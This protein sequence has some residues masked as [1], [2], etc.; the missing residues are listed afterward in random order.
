MPATLLDARGNEAH[1]TPY[2]GFPLPPPVPGRYVVE[3]NGN[4]QYRLPD[5]VTGETRSFDR[6]TSLSKVLD[7]PYLLLRWEK[8][9]LLVGLFGTAHLQANLDQAVGE[10]LRSSDNGSREAVRAL[11]EPLNE[12]AAEAERRAGGEYYSEF[13]TAVHAWTDYLDLGLCVLADVPEIFRD[14]CREYLETCAVRG[15]MMDPQYNERVVYNSRLKMAGTIDRFILNPRDSFYRHTLGDVKTSRT[16]E[17]SWLG[18]GVQ[19]GFYSDCDL[20]LAVDGSYWMPMPDFNTDAGALINV[21]SDNADGTHIVPIELSVGRDLLSAAVMIRDMR[22]SA[23]TSIPVGDGSLPIRDPHIIRVLQLRYAVQLA[24][25]TQTLVSLW[26]RNQ[27]IWTD[28]LTNIG[29]RTVHANANA[30]V[31]Q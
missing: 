4:N 30:K 2:H 5:P 16:L 27:D 7:D 17:Y 28:D 11:R 29:R 23:K 12:I 22:R 25:D 13:G 31:N 8:R 14:H 18:F 15:F 9:N 10:F 6:A 21:P 19:L 1:T 24:P 26:E 3:F 20:M